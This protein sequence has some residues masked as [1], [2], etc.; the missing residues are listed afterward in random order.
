M[1][2]PEGS[3]EPTAREWAEALWLAE[4]IGQ[5]E[6]PPGPDRETDDR[7]TGDRDTGGPGVD[8]RETGAA[9][10]GPSGAPPTPED[11]SEAADTG[12]GTDTGTDDGT[13]PGNGAGGT[14]TATAHGPPAPGAG[15]TGPAVPDGPLPALPRISHTL[16]SGRGAVTGEELPG[17]L[18]DARGLARA[19]RPLNR[20]L[21]GGSRRRVLD[22]EATAV[23][24]AETGQWHPVLTRPPDRWFEVALV[25]E[26]SVSMTVWQPVA[27]AFAELLRTQ[28]AFADVRLWSL[29]TRDGKHAVLCSAD[30][31]LRHSPAELFHPDGRRIVL[32]MSDCVGDAW[33]GGAVP[34]LLHTWGRR[35]PVAVLQP[36]PTHLWDL[37]DGVPMDLRVRAFAPGLP[38]SRLELLRYGRWERPR[39]SDPADPLPVP[40]PVLELEPG[41]FTGWA[42]MVTG[43][44][45]PW[46][47]TT[48]LLVDEQGLTPHCLPPFTWEER[49]RPVPP[50]LAVR[51]FLRHASPAARRLAARLAMV[52]L[53]PEVVEAVRQG[54]VAAGGPLPFAEILLGGLLALRTTAAQ[55]RT[56]EEY[57][58]EFLDGVRSRLLRGLGRTELLRTLQE[59]S[60][61]A[62]RAVGA[63][64][65]LLRTV[66]GSR[67]R[68]EADTLTDLD[69]ELLDAAGPALKALGPPYGAVW[70]PVRG[71]APFGPVTT[72]EGVTAEEDPAGS[73]PAD[74]AS[75]TGGPADGGAGGEGDG[76]HSGSEAGAGAGSPQDNGTT[77]PNAKDTVTMEPPAAGGTAP[78]VTSPGPGDTGTGTGTGTGTT[79]PA[80]SGQSRSPRSVPLPNPHFA[81]RENEL[82]ELHRQLG[83][84]TRAA[85]LP[86]AL[87]GLGGVGKTQLALKYVQLHR[88]E[89]DRV[90]WIDAE[91]PA[92][93]RAQLTMLAP[94]LGLVPDRQSDT[95]ARVLAALASGAPHSRWLLVF[96]NAGQPNEVIPYLPSLIGD[97][98]GTGRILITSRHA[99]W[100]DRVLATKVDVF[101]RAESLDFLRAR[102][103]WAGPEQADQ[104]AELLG[105]LPLALEQCAALQRQ[106]GIAV[107]DFLTMIEQ[108]RAEVLAEGVDSITL[109]VAV[110]WR[111]SMETLA[112][113]A[114]GALEL[115]RLLAFF[116]PEPVALDFLH[117]ARMLPL[118]PALMRLARDPLSRGR[119]IRAINQFSLLT[120]DNV[121]GTVQMHR[122]VR[123]VLQDELPAPEQSEMRHLVHQV[124]AAHDPGD[125]QR[126]EHWQN[127][128]DIL[129]H[130]EPT[131]LPRCEDRH[132][133]DTAINMITYLLARGVLRGAAQLGERISTDWQSFLG[134]DDLQTLWATRHRASAHWQLAEFAVSRPLSEEVL[135]RLRETV[136]D[137]HEYT[138]TAAGVL[139]AD[140]RTAGRF[141]DA[142]E[143][144]EDAYRR[145]VNMYGAQDP[146]TLR[147]GHNYG[148]SLRVN[149]RYGEA[150]DLD[151]RVHQDL[152]T[153][154]GATALST[155]F[156]VNNVA[157]DMRECGEYA[158]ALELQEQTLA[159][160][161]AQYGDRHPHTMRAIKNMSVTCR[162]A[163]RFD[164]AR[165]LAEE[166]LDLYVAILGP[167]HIDTLAA[168][169][170]L[171]NDL[172]LTGDAE[173][174]ER[175]GAQALERYR[176]V[177]GTEHPLTHVA[178]V[179]HGAA[180]R[181][182]GKFPQ[183]LRL[184]QETAPGLERVLHETHPWALLA[185][186]N[187][188]TGLA[189]TGE[190]EAARDLGERC[191]R[192]LEERYGDRHPATLAALRNVSLDLVSCG[193]EERGAE[194]LASVVRRY[195]ETLGAEHG[196]TLSAEAGRRAE[197]DI[198]PPP[199]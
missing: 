58:F 49:R 80:P 159:Q 39:D 73:A 153:V 43:G 70:D 33:A 143:L 82:A 151:R 96:D 75:R 100:S 3:A 180:L 7:D 129:P 173:A 134:V 14:A 79:G 128:A 74:G 174:A 90:W 88:H 147:A 94:E 183:A 139:A 154:L 36:L 61:L 69:R 130:L 179:N 104:L 16:S 103:P 109:P 92:V 91:Q 121:A 34:R 8:G 144:D 194:L 138:L 140:L 156:S 93:I 152:R 95:V 65:D 149:G 62:G 28:G 197:C 63:R 9:P 101:T 46:T 110:V 142:L 98:E 44:A 116:G 195:H 124:I 196:E 171:A 136:G 187:L 107:P 188:A 157:R 123:A 64:P 72:G 66:I 25:V 24:A 18:R 76:P 12:T 135:R 59:T 13:H 55:G 4:V 83:A 81:G 161:R 26:R 163:G 177:L 113:Q 175:Q 111:A 60:A 78:G 19:L 37:C 158:A 54:P 181:A 56:G 114:P 89:Y 52:P 160:Y 45:L 186:V 106:T 10:G 17:A 169:A 41:W 40:V 115:L 23:R 20:R 2:G 118:P 84:S 102:A 192:T 182:V 11:T 184:D 77:P 170:N 122:L 145:S 119:A 148:V 165:T 15:A 150:L 108:R 31:G 141:A 193:E 191:A 146:F 105:D 47:E 127:Y 155:L 97:S 198:E 51:R 85:V 87:H 68:P 190:H 178:A 112:T 42:R 35:A 117:D 199:L 126:S 21:P 30:G 32:V 71:T 57:M 131:G 189:R 99:G 38:N 86:H 22:E 167:M 27:R 29:D 185:H 48:S 132:I 120:V 164:R 176:T 1:T 67:E 5:E 133:R 168:F 172:R 137:D 166:V 6:G 50:D 162:K 53:R 125:T